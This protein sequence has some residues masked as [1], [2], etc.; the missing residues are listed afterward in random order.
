MVLIGGP[1][2]DAGHTV[3]LLDNDLYGWSDS[4]LVSQ[5]R[6]NPPACVLLGHTSSTAAHPVAMRTA[7]TLREAFPSAVIVY[8]GVYASY[9]SEQ[10]LT[11]NPELDAVVRGEGEQTVLELAAAIAAHGDGPGLPSLQDVRGITWRG[12]TGIINNPSRAPIADLDRYRPGWE[13]VDWPG[14]RLFGFGRS[15]GV[16]FSRGCTLSCTY[17]GQ[18]SFWRKWRHRS[19]ED[20]ADQLELLATQ[21]GVRIVWLAD[22]NFAADRE[23]ARQALQAVADRRLDLSLNLNMTAADVVRDA[24]LLPLYKRA[25]VDNIVMGVESTE[26]V[27]VKK[28]R[29]NN[30]FAI[31]CQATRLLREHNIVGLVNIIYGLEEESFSSVWR[32]FRQVLKMDPDVLNA[33]YLTPHHW[34]VDGRNTTPDQIVQ[35]D[36]HFWTYRNQVLATKRMRPTHLFLA[37]KLT[38]AL[39]HLRPRSLYRMLTAHDHRYRKILRAYLLVGTRVVWAE[40]VE[41]FFQA[42]QVRP[43]VLREI[44]GFPRG[45]AS[46]I[47]QLTTAPPLVS[48][49]TR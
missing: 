38:E 40:L 17:C 29:K 23:A 3:R 35:P 5:L 1:L 8:G 24:D 12:P 37:I 39:F 18:W 9:A 13:L 25:G 4:E 15:A 27:T 47:V 16:Q 46:P 36:Q 31:S 2:V 49:G 10:V 45:Q 7:R 32:T 44:P 28:V 14:Y 20:L 30:P 26:D 33:V 6:E 42:P 21:Y 11:D 41:Y 22:E 19:A 43:G 34:T 48:A